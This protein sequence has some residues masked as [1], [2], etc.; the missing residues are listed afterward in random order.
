MLRIITSLLLLI[1]IGCKSEE[2]K[3][4]FNNHKTHRT[5]YENGKIKTIGQFNDNNQ[6]IGNWFYYDSTGILR[7]TV[8]YFLINGESYLNQEWN[9]T[10]LGDTI[11]DRGTYFE[12]DLLSDTITLNEPV[13]A[14]VDLTSPFFKQESSSIYVIVPKDYSKNFNED[15]SNLQEVDLDTTF[16]LNIEL[17]MRKDIGLSPNTDFRRTAVFGRYYQTVGIKKFRGIIVEEFQIEESLFDSI[18]PDFYKKYGALLDHEIADTSSRD[19]L[20]INNI[21]MHKYFER[22]LMVLD[23]L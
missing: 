2:S 20:K 19:S 6:P 1:F 7:K 16:N 18:S 23:S 13:R 9:F 21:L 22:D 4:F 15:F 14:K 5:F 12:L 8:E 11:K 10:K 3:G 17:E